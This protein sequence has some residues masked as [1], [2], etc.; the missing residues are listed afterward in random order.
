MLHYLVEIW[1]KPLTGWLLI[2]R[3]YWN[4]SCKKRK[5]QKISFDFLQSK[6]WEWVCNYKAKRNAN[7]MKHLQ[8]KHETSAKK[9]LTCIINCKNISHISSS[10]LKSKYLFS[11]SSS[12]TCLFYKIINNNDQNRP[13]MCTC[14]DLKLSCLT[15]LPWD[16]IFCLLFSPKEFILSAITD[17]SVKKLKQNQKVKGKENCLT[18]TCRVK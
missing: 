3:L 15:R 13:H 5:A 8:K 18:C 1:L 12:I 4:F 7:R 10:S 6:G 14:K 2:A 11:P 16:S 9:S 17:E